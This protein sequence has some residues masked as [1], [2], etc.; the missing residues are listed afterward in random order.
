MKLLLPLGLL[1]LLGIVALIIIYLI[2]PNYQQKLISSTYIWKLS[3]K[4]RKRKIPISRLRN[5]LLVLCQVLII[6]SCTAVLTKPVEVLR[7]QIE[8]QEVILIID[9]S[10]SM[11]ATSGEATRYERAVR[12]AIAKA[13]TVFDNDGI[14]SVILCDHKSS[15]LVERATAQSRDLTI[16]ELEDLLEDDLACSYTTTDM[17]AA[18]ALSD[19]VLQV[20]PSA[21]ITIYSDTSFAYVPENIKM[22]NVSDSEEWNAAILNAEAYLEDNYYTFKVEVACYGRDLDLA[23]NLQIFGAN[24]EDAQDTTAGNILLSDTVSCSGDKTVTLYFKY[25]PPDDDG[26]FENS[27]PDDAYLSKIEDTTRVFSYQSVHISIEEEDALSS[28]N[29]FDIY[30]GLKEVIKVQYYSTGKDPSTGDALGPNVFFQQVL[31][32]LDKI[33]ANRWDIQ[34]TE[35]KSGNPYATEGFDFYIFEHTMPDKMPTD[36]FV[37]LADPNSVPD[38]AGFRLDSLV[39]MSKK[40]VYLAA[41]EDHPLLNNM[42]PTKITVSRYVK[43]ASYDPS[44][45]PLMSYAN[46]PLF[47]VKNEGESRVAVM[48]FSLHYS[49]LPLLTEFPQMMYNMFEYFC[50]ATVI[51]NAFETYEST[52]VSCRGDALKIT[53]YRYDSTLTTFPTEISFSMPGSYVLTQTTYSGKDVTETIYVK[54]PSAESNIRAEGGAITSPY[55]EVNESDFYHDLLLYLAIA[56][57]LLLT[58]EW[59]LQHRENSL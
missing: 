21:S 43:L 51:G 17:N 13:N 40:S 10:A 4:Y 11:R 37:L 23:I 30:G 47:L 50:P 28:D 32:A 44:Y 52:K 54:V 33:Y 5:I 25:I 12:R 49:N 14:V 26:S 39:D 2:R 6:V 34:I 22:E 36:G 45:T 46:D 48:L 42:D 16:T 20:N 57:V 15:Y 35:V 41:E 24:A 55:H 38:N 31:A 7:E 9:S 53:G 8:Q 27:L 29:N 3:L 19:N 59:Y 58:V 18:V 1:G 56:L